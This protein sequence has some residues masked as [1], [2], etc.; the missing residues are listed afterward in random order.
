MIGGDGRME[1]L[2]QYVAMLDV[3]GSGAGHFWTVG[4]TFGS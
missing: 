3:P 4:Y 1:S 2:L